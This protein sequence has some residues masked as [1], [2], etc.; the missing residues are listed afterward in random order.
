MIISKDVMITEE[1][2]EK[3]KREIM[4]VLVTSDLSK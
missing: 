4:C 3:L 2:G 1:D